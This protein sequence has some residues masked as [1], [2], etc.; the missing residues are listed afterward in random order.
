[1]SE[2]R[3]YLWDDRAFSFRRFGDGA[4]AIARH[5]GVEISDDTYARWR[6]TGGL[7]REVDS[8]YD[9]DRVPWHNLMER[10][11]SYD[12]FRDLYPSLSP[13]VM[14]PEKRERLI[15]VAKFIFEA[16][17]R[18]AEATVP[19]DY[20]L[21]RYQ[22]GMGAAHLLTVTASDEEMGQPGYPAFV[23]EF[24]TFITGL[25]FLDTYLDSVIDYST[26]KSRIKPNPEYFQA[27]RQVARPA[28][29]ASFGIALRPSIARQGFGMAKDRIST[30][31]RNGMTK[32]STMQN[33]PNFFHN[34]RDKWKKHRLE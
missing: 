11:I 12:E 24:E 22:E 31:L 8:H 21:H 15:Q 16:G 6:E 26:G 7:M 32:Y 9:D 28:I 4:K 14:K 3:D 5:H 30:R 1:M 29:F 17:Q 25:T 18:A 27:L 34:L 19:S 13:E 10:L 2:G 20:V 33:V 23:E